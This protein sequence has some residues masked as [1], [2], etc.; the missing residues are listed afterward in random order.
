[1]YFGTPLWLFFMKFYGRFVKL[2]SYDKFIDLSL[3]MNYL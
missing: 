3:I 1:M 2:K